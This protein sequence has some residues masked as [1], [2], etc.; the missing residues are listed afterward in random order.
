MVP[1]LIHG[2]EGRA[3]KRTGYLVVSVE[4][5]LGS[6][7][8]PGVRCT[9]DEDLAK[10]AGLPSYGSDLGAIDQCFLE[11]CRSQVTNFKGHSYLSHFLCF[12]VGGW[13]YKRHP[14]VVDALLTEVVASLRRLFFEGVKTKNGTIFA[15]IAGVKG[16]LEFHRKYLRLERSYANVGTKS[17]IA[18]CHLCLA[19]RAGVPAEDYSE[20]PQWLQ[21]LYLERPW[22]MEK[23]PALSELPYDSTCPEDILKLDIFHVLRLGVARDIVG[24]VLVI[25]LRLKFFDHEGS[26]V[27]LDDRFTRAHGHF[28]L[29][30]MANS[31]CPGL[32]SFSKHF[33]NMVTLMSAPWAS[34]KGS[35]SML[36]L[37]WLRF[38]LKIQLM[39]PT[40][41]GH[42]LLLG[43]MLQVVEAAL[44]IRLIH[45]HRLWLER[46]CAKNLYVNIMT[47]LRGY[48]LLARSSIQLRIRAFIQK[49]KHHSLHHLAVFLK[50]ELEKGATI[51]LSPQAISCDLNEDYLGRIARLSRRVGFK[52]CDLRVIH[53]YML[54]VS[55]L[56]RKR[57]DPQKG[58][59]RKVWSKRWGKK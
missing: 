23:E 5:P 40:V 24:G 11:I 53:R 56:L 25:L 27:N 33:F 50:T 18:M 41:P 59:V 34:S 22:S 13:V 6:L 47:L 12:G 44:A 28:S 10:R 1:L 54:K 36:L 57:V 30:C 46:S 38:V 21:T 16:D 9:C 48:A 3:V 52:L 26:S 39:S 31:K 20:S 45:H 58:E 42:E 55:L 19:G 2:D 17:Q 43:H 4:S 15:A 49:P 35:D 32:R 29:W 51:I 37:E 7:D 14:S 8:D